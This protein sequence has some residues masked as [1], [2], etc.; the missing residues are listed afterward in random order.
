MAEIE[1]QRAENQRIMAE[2]LEL[3]KQLADKG[4]NTPPSEN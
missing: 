2:L 4:E 3:K 1:E